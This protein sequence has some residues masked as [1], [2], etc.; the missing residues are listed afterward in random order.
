VLNE[1]STIAALLDSIISQIKKPD[2]TIFIDGGSSDRTCD[3]INNYQNIYK[4]I[5]VLEFKTTR[6]EA[7]NI[8]IRYSKGEVIV[9]TDA[10]CV[11]EKHWIKK[12]T[13]P[14]LNKNIDV[15]AGFY[16]MVGNTP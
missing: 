14:F 3:I 6:S 7:R 5:K 9:T 15:V 4:N 10:G 8:G 16:E 12:I 13:E 11:A 1:E 2:E